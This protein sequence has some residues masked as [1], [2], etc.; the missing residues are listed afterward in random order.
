M[1]MP[2]VIEVPVRLEPVTPDPF[3]SDLTARGGQ[4]IGSSSSSVSSTL[5]ASASRG[6]AAP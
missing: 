2:H 5:S 4:P 3:V 1:T 6:A